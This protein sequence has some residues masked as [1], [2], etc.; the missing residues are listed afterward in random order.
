MLFVLGVT[1]LLGA[2][3]TFIAHNWVYLSTVGKLGL[4]GVFLLAAAVAWVLTRFESGV[5]QSLGILA[6]VLIGVWLAA[7]G[8]LYQVPGG[9]Q[10][11]L[12]TWA[13]LGV[14]FALASK[15]YAHWALWVGVVALALI[16]PIGDRLNFL[17][18][19]EESIRT[20]LAAAVTAAAYAIAVWRSGDMWFRVLMA[21]AT[22]ALL[23]TTAVQ[24]MGS[25]YGQD[26]LGYFLALGLAGASAV[27]AWSRRDSLAE[28]SSFGF[29]V[30]A[31]G[32]TLLLRMFLETISGFDIVSII[33]VFTLIFGGA[34]YGLIRLFKLI[35]NRVSQMEEDTE[36]DMPWYMDALIAMGGFVTALFVAALVGVFFGL[37]LGMEE[38]VWSILLVLG[39]LGFAGFLFLRRNAKGLFTKYLSGTLM[40]AS[41][42]AA[43]VGLGG[44]TE[45]LVITSI[46]GIVL[47][48]IGL[49][50]IRERVLETVFAAGIASSVLLLIEDSLSYQQDAWFE[51]YALVI[52]GV[53][54]VLALSY[55]FSGRH[56]MAAGALWLVAIVGTGVTM[57][58]SLGVTSGLLDNWPLSGWLVAWRFG[59]AVC[60]V[61]IARLSPIGKTL[62]SLP[63]LVLLTAIA[64]LLP[65][66]GVGAYLLLL[67]GYALGSKSLALIGAIVTGFFL[68]WAYFDLNLTL[69]EL[70]GIMAL[71]GLVL[72]GIWKFAVARAKREDIV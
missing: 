14:P 59:I 70:S 61:A 25:F 23:I 57:G 56:F 13:V 7:A 38:S 31:I 54:G 47:S 28:L 34:T 66:G 3:I 22:T 18:G 53:L 65:A 5:S 8:Q 39:L 10:D 19:S 48:A 32:V 1:S 24:A 50:A 64:A 55:R 42:V 68:Y 46:L 62:P 40:V 51:I 29:G 15:S 27:W 60:L 58:N 69:L 36:G 63:I 6:Q 20:F 33:L 2:V 26:L 71:S 49:F 35:R 11:L 44:S 37:T 17:S 52:L 21:V 4:L 45:D 12:L 67:L 72:L 9:I 41:G 30:L 16:S 43:V